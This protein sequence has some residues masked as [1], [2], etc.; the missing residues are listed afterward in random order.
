MSKGM[1]RVQ[2][3]ILATLS[4]RPPLTRDGDLDALPLDELA[5]SVYPDAQSID[6]AQIEAVRRS[7]FKLA[8]NGL[9]QVWRD[10]RMRR[11]VFELEAPRWIVL[12]TRPLSDE[13]EQRRQAKL[14]QAHKRFIDELNELDRLRAER[15]ALSS[16]QSV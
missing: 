15:E 9:V 3:A 5:A 14:D 8:D 12:F 11:H 16:P 1:G 6:R 13:E 10:S 2:R 7:A 4:A